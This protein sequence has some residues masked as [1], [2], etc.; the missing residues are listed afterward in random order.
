MADQRAAQRHLV[1]LLLLSIAVGACDPS[2]PSTA[3]T[4]TV[5][6]A[7]SAPAVD[8]PL[9]EPSF[10]PSL[11]PVEAGRSLY[12]QLEC[13]GC[14]ESAAVPGLVV[15]PLVQLR[16]RFDEASLAAFLS[17]PPP[18]MPN[19]ELSP[20]ERHALAAFLLRRFD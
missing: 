13:A 18:P 17:A 4:P 3:T 9:E 20:P 7:T 10:D 8:E 14:H 16:T 5:P 19:F 2:G 12:R 11:P 15:V 6:D 1:P